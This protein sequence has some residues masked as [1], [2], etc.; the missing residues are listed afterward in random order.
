MAVEMFLDIAGVKG[1]SQ[2][3][4]FEN[5]IDIFSMS[6]GASNPSQASTGSGSGAGKVSLS[7]VSI[8]KVVDAASPT[9][10]RSC[11]SGAHFD[12]GKITIREAGGDAAVE[13]MV[14]DLKQVFVDSVSWGSASGG[15]KPSESISL[16][17]VELTI[18]YTSQTAKGAGQKGE[19]AGWN[20]KTNTKTA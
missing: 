15:E 2:V 13:Y 10:F 16:S 14:I 4:G 6:F 11:C 19:S 7:S 3:K 9:L 12:T 17:A 1:E 18:T 8:Q 20:V 5:K